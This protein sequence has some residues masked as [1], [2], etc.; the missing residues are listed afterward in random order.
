METPKFGAA[1]AADF[2]ERFDRRDWSSHPIGARINRSETQIEIGS[3]DYRTAWVGVP[4][5]RRRAGHNGGRERRNKR[6]KSARSAGMLKSQE[7]TQPQLEGVR[8]K[9]AIADGVLGWA[10]SRYLAKR[11]F[12]SYSVS[13]ADSRPAEDRRKEHRRSVRL[14]SGKVI[15]ENERFLGDCLLRNRTKSGSRLLLCQYARLPKRILLFDDQSRTLALAAVI[16]QR[17]REVG[18]RILWLDA[19][20]GARL[21]KRFEARYYAAR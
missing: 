16:W 18:C 2:R 21:A 12:V 8:L 11:G 14:Q 5:P 3:C 13:P 10:S 7:E 20:K 9:G 1:R 4:G 6:H 19:A 15:D 17:D